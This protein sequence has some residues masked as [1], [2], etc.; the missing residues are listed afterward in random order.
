VEQIKHGGLARALII[1]SE[2]VQDVQ[3]FL[4]LVR[5]SLLH[6]KKRARFFLESISMGNL[7]FLS[8]PVGV[9]LPG[10]NRKMYPVFAIG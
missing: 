9:I 1:D 2:N 6:D 5:I 4:E 3:E 7:L 10:L 8:A